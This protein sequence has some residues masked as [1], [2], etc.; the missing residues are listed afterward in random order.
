MWVKSDSQPKYTLS[1]RINLTQIFR[2][3]KVSHF[4]TY[5][6]GANQEEVH[7]R[8]TLEG[9]IKTPLPF[10]NRSTFDFGNGDQLLVKEGAI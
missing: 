9:S 10:L 3:V 2:G 7:R 4:L 6:N 8:L 1:F 5:T